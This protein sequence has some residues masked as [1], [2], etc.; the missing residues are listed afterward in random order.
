MRQAREPVL[1]MDY[2]SQTGLDVLK[3]SDIIKKAPELYD[4]DRGISG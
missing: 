3:G 4:L 1:V 2:L